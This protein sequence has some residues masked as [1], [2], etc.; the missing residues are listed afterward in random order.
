MSEKHE[1]SAKGLLKGRNIVRCAVIN[2]PG[3]SNMCT[4]F[5]DALDRPLRGFTV[6][7][8]EVGK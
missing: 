8:G 5:L 4:R 7:V 3:L 2:S 6:S 1:E